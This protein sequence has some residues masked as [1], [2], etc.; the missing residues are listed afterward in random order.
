[1]YGANENQR[2]EKKKCRYESSIISLAVDEGR[3]GVAETTKS[4]DKRNLPPHDDS[5]K[6]HKQTHK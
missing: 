6:Q 4:I 5:N 2:K 3:R 1:M